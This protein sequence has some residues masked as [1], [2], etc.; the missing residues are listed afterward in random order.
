MRLLIVGEF[1]GVAKNLAIGFN[2]LNIETYLIG[3]GD[4]YKN[5]SGV[6]RNIIT[7][8]ILWRWSNQIIEAIS[9]FKS[10]FDFVIFLSPFIFKYP[11]SLNKW[12]YNG[13][14][15]SSKKSILLCCTSDSVWWRDYD[16]MHGR[17]PHLGSILDTHGKT[18]RY[19]DNKHYK[20]NLALIKTVDSVIGLA[21][22]YK[23]AYDAHVANVS[24]IPFPYK[25]SELSIDTKGR[26][27][28]YHGI[29]RKGFKG[30]KKLLEVMKKYNSFGLESLVTA[31]ISYKSFIKNLKQSVVYLDQAYS[32]APAMA[33]L[34]A[35]EYVPYVIT[36]IQP[37]SINAEY[38]NDCPAYDI[39]SDMEE[40]NNIVGDAS[41]YK[42]QLEE[43]HEFL[44]KHHDPKKI[45]NLIL[46][47]ASLH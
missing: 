19:A 7:S 1:S 22:E 36:G 21:P 35:L 3:D 38:Y 47:E 15:E 34:N 41:L 11:L 17:S 45:C 10:S 44:K 24:W 13:L 46:D 20:E 5:M 6:N 25:K 39:F 31:Q 4:S 16:S 26:Q 23:L 2:E 28:A 33:S 8:S 30:T 29:T 14:I 18:H 43:N 12:L 32:H 27:F 40:F 9:Q 37:N 42:K